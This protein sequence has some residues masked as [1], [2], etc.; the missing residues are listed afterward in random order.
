MK[1]KVWRKDT[2]FVKSEFPKTFYI[3]RSFKSH[4]ESI[5]DD[6]LTVAR[7]K[8]TEAKF[9]S[10]YENTKNLGTRN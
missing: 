7:F 6:G 4:Q 5:V 3:S 9:R 1:R 8:L 10:K 2:Y